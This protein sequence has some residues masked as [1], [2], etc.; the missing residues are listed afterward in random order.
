MPGSSPEGDVPETNG[1]DFA[2]TAEAAKAVETL[3]D[4][5][6]DDLSSIESI[7]SGAVFEM[8]V[9]PGHRYVLTY[10][11]QSEGE[12]T[13]RELVDYVIQQ[14]DHT[15][16]P[17]VFRKLLVSRL[18]NTY[19]PDLAESGFVRYNMERQMVGPTKLTPLV[20]PYLQIA[21][22][23]QKSVGQDDET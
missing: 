13:C 23:Q 21:L 22:A 12:I 5:S 11:L 15:M 19:L 3:V 1:V 16:E 14:T 10:L 7:D 18:T 2:T 8:L 9:N 4:D 20:R 6:E 17:R